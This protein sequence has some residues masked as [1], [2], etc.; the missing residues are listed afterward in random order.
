[1]IRRALES[2]VRTEPRATLVENLG[3]EGYF[4]AMARAGAMV[5]NSSSGIVEAASFALPVVNIGTRQRGR[6]RGE[7]VLDVDYDRAAIVAGVRRA[8]SPDF[9]ATFAGIVNPYG[10]GH[11]AA[12]IVNRLEE[13]PLDERLIAK[14]FVDV[15]VTADSTR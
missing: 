11:A 1:M 8:L 10:D 4:S 7:N 12:A 15:T 9:R 3:T 14:R 2:F 6:I 13:V 5:G